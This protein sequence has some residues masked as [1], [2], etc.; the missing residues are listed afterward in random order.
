MKYKTPI[1]FL[2][3]LFASSCKHECIPE[4]GVECHE[5]YDIE[6]ERFYLQQGGNTEY[7]VCGDFLVASDNASS[8]LAYYMPKDIPDGL[9]ISQGRRIEYKGALRIFDSEH[10]CIDGRVDPKPGKTPWLS[11]KHVTILSWEEL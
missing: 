7:D 8:Y 11:M 3:L 4:P 9:S 5:P 1:L 6:V 10:T 2:T